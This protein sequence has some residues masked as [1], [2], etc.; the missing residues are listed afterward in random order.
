MSYASEQR[1]IAQRM[2]QERGGWQPHLS[3]TQRFIADF[4]SGNRSKSINILGSGWLFDV[5]IA[6]I[7]GQFNRVVL[8][9]IYHPRQIVHRY[10]K[11]ANVEFRTADLTNGA[12]GL[13]YSA[14]RRRFN[15]EEYIAKVQRLA[16]VEL[17]E[18]LVISV[19][20]LSQLSVFITDY[21]SQRARLSHGQLAAI[22]AAIQRG[23][24]NALPKS[25]SVVVTDYEEEFRD[26]E[27][28]LIGTRPTVFVDI[29]QDRHTQEWTWQ[30]DTQMTYREDCRTYLKVLAT[31][32]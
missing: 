3:N 23:H 18:D 2:H 30:F 25:R 13:A 9:D 29:P 1:Y 15:P 21:L 16:P 32:I 24:L 17:G 31:R 7:I 27:D 11:H 22:A 5:P 20:L 10:A 6:S 12:V 4:L 8:T 19:N 14:G 28:G 26:E